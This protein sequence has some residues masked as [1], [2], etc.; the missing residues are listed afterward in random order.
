[1]ATVPTDLRQ[2]PAVVFIVLGG[3][4]VATLDISY[5]SLY[6]GLKAHVPVHRIFQSVAAGLLGTASFEG[7][8]ATAALGL[9]LHYGIAM[10]MA[11]SYYLVARRW[12]L[13]TQ[14]PLWCGAAYGV[15]LYC[16]MQY[17]VLPLSAVKQG[18]AKDYLWVTLSVFV[19]ALLIGVPIAFFTRRA[20]RT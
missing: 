2:S 16:V 19:H 4:F 14:R 10:A 12:P 11:V 7:G 3:L 20:L 9:A 17:V 1:V 6:W 13:L 15:L 5:A 8:A 18:G